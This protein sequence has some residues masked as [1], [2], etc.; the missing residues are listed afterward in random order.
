MKL[1]DADAALFF[2]LMLSLQIYANQQLKLVPPIE[3]LVDFE[4]R[5]V[6]E[7]MVIR[8]ALYQHPELIDRFISENPQGFEP[9][10]LKI[11]DSWKGFRAGIFYIERFLKKYTV[12]ISDTDR[13]YGVLGLR[14]SLEDIIHKSYLPLMVKAV[15]LPFKGQIVYD[16]L[17]QS[18]NIIFGGGI[19]SDLKQLYL[20]AKNAGQIIESFDPVQRQSVV[21]VMPK[22]SQDFAPLLDDLA[23][24]AKVLRGGNGQP[25]L[26][27]P[28]YSLIKASLELGQLALNEPDNEVP[29]MK[30]RDRAER[31]LQK[32]DSSLYGPRGWRL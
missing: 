30:A 3:D 23:Q 27:G 29:L 21:K 20:A 11:I 28:I 1:S 15:L 4:A 17:F 26:N 5:P 25:P 16:G 32:I 7:K 14:D 24:R 31:A 8:D 13:V 6:E 12:F 18:R 19:K 22:P 9:D 2:E 10:Q